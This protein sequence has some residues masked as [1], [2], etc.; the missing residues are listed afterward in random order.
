[1]ILFK[2]NDKVHTAQSDSAVFMLLLQFWIAR[3]KTGR[4]MLGYLILSLFHQPAHYSISCPAISFLL[5][6][7]P[8]TS[9]PHTHLPFFTFL[10][11]ILWNSWFF[12]FVFHVKEKVAKYK[13]VVFGLPV[14]KDYVYFNNFISLSNENARWHGYL[15]VNSPYDTLWYYN[16]SNRYHFK[17]MNSL[18]WEIVN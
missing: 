5:T 7:I 10:W 8:D 12:L 4:W 1:M 2:W 9:L 6:T 18:H 15:H 11:N 3:E 14:L 17:N 16:R 13:E